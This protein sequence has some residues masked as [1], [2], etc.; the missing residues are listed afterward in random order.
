M[1]KKKK[2]DD[3]LHLCLKTFDPAF[4]IFL[5]IEKKTMKTMKKRTKN[6][7]N[8]EN[9]KTRNSDEDFG[10]CSFLCDSFSCPCFGFG[11]CFGFS[12]QESDEK[13]CPVCVNENDDA[14]D[15]CFCSC[16]DSCFSLCG[17]SRCCC[18]GES[19]RKKRMRKRRR[20]ERNGA[21]GRIG[22]RIEKSL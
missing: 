6:D 10:S 3:D 11:F 12:H 18:G 5:T 14:F 9:E 19:E 22:L 21:N 20:N 15:L 2:S 8:D 7:A 4:W 13:T 1:K 17:F 16:F